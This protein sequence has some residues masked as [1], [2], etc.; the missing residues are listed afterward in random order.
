MTAFGLT[1]W[2]INRCSW[3]FGYNTYVNPYAVGDTVIIDNSV[4]DY[5]QPLIM[6]PDEQTL[7]ADPMDLPDPSVPAASLTAFDQAR[8]AFYAGDYES[9]LAL[10]NDA[11]KENPNDA[12]IHEFRALTLFALGEYQDSAATLYAVLSVGPGWDWTTMAGLYPDVA[13]YTTQLRALEKYVKENLDDTA[14]LLV[15]SYHYITAG[16]DDAAASQL[17]RLVQLT[18]NDPVAIQLLLEVDPDATLP[19]VP[20]EIEPPKPD[21]PIAKAE[22]VGSWSAERDSRQFA[23]VLKEDDSFSWTYTEG[24]QSQQVTGIWNVDDQGVLAMEMNDEGVMLAQ[25]ILKDGELDFYM[26]G[27]TQGS[28]PLHFVHQ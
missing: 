5:S 13:T 1:S 25:V 6:T 26:V 16:H 17:S 24:D 12:V 3:A 22:L 21:A 15:L 9:A 14:G 23:M 4:Y 27:D 18:P 7:S 11:L 8:Q 20:K 10:T 2:A 19:E 28:P